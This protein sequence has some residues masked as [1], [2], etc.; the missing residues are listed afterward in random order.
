MI[1]PVQK[2]SKY[3]TGVCNTKKEEEKRGIR[4]SSP[5]LYTKTTISL[6]VFITTIRYENVLINIIENTLTIDLIK[7]NNNTS[8]EV[9]V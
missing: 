7:M 1:F 9:F 5:I 3:A 2:N 8:T 4:V 6:V